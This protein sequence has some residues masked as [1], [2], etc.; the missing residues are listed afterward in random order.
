M[1]SS[2]VSRVRYKHHYLATNNITSADGF[3]KLKILA[4]AFKFGLSI[5][6]NHGHLT[7]LLP[8]AG[9]DLDEFRKHMPAISFVI[10]DGWTTRIVGDKVYFPTAEEIRFAR[11]VAEQIKFVR[12]LNKCLIKYGYGSGWLLQQFQS[13]YCHTDLTDSIIKFAK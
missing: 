9:W 2:P 8:N 12:I 6:D 11:L 13:V 4:D 5:T 3:T 10:V 1:C 7:I